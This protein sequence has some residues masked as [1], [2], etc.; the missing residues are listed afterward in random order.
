LRF[1]YNFSKLQTKTEAGML[2]KQPEQTGKLE[3]VSHYKKKVLLKGQITAEDEVKPK[4][5]RKVI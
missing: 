4:N 2:A 5:N 1:Q 3:E